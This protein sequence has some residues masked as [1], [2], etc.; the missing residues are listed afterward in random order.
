MTAVHQAVTGMLFVLQKMSRDCCL[1]LLAVTWVLLLVTTG[2][3]DLP[4]LTAFLPAP[5]A[6][7]EIGGG[8]PMLANSSGNMALSCMQGPDPAFPGIWT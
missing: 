7:G 6:G 5:Y 3:P 8:N 1:W 4:F 2:E